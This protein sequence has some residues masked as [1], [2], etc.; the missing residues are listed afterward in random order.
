MHQGRHLDELSGE[1]QLEIDIN[2]Q[3][4]RKLLV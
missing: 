2:L 3:Y 4:L 1:S